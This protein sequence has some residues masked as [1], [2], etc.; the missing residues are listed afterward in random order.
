LPLLPIPTEVDIPH[1]SRSFLTWLIWKPS[2]SSR[3]FLIFVI[4]H[5]FSF[6]IPAVG[7]RE[8]ILMAFRM[9]TRYRPA[10]MTENVGCARRPVSSIHQL[11]SF[12]TLLIG[13]PSS[14]EVKSKKGGVKS[15]KAGYPPQSG[16]YD[17]KIVALFRW[18]E[19]V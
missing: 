12:P 4:G 3:H 5:Q 17:G 2:F 1:S 10:G 8:S 18:D 9:D 19:V 16:E 14:E 6:V 7:Y 11:L 15:K 13:N